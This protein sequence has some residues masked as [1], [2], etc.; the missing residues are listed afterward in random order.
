MRKL[1]YTVV[2]R[3]IQPA[4]NAA[5]HDKWRVSRIFPGASDIHVWLASHKRDHVAP[6]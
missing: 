3:I 6:V 2:T 4:V 5:G 1:Q